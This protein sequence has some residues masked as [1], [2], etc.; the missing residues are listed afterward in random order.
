MVGGVRALDTQKVKAASLIS[1]RAVFLTHKVNT[2]NVI[3]VSYKRVDR[4]AHEMIDSL[5]DWRS[6]TYVVLL[7]VGGSCGAIYTTRLSIAFGEIDQS[8][9]P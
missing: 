2:R 3:I 1:T 7:S 9:D 4:M 5:S 6:N 8:C